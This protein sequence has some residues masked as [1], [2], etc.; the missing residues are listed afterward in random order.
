MFDSIC[1]RYD[2]M[3]TL[4]TLGQ[5]RKWRRLTVERAELSPGSR[6]L[7]V[8]CGTGMLLDELLQMVGSYGEAVGLDFSEKM[9]AVARRN[10]KPSQNLRQ[11]YGNYRLLQGDAQNLPFASNTFDG[12]T[13]GWGLRNIQDYRRVL[14]EM[15][16]VVR[17]GGKII[18]LEIGHPE[19]SILPRAGHLLYWWGFRFLV[20]FLG[21]LVAQ[22]AAAYNYLYRSAQKF[23]SQQQLA[24]IFAKEGLQETGYFNLAG[25]IVAI[26]EGRKPTN[27]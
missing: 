11:L 24:R 8:C 27:I 26:V 5:D 21:G 2:L 19:I 15:I 7:D 4:M 14:Q 13:I 3:N 20:P 12:V 9:L 16:R 25:G 23:P 17:P 18:S 10:L 1:R 6:A 22:N